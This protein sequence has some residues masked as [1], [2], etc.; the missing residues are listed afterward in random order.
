[1]SFVK[2]HA[3][4]WIQ[5]SG[6][7]RVVVVENLLI[8][9]ASQCVFLGELVP[10]IPEL[11][12]GMCVAGGFRQI[13]SAGPAD[14]VFGS[15]IGDLDQGAGLE[16]AP[17]VKHPAEYLARMVPAGVKEH[18]SIVAGLNICASCVDA[19][20]Y[21][22]DIPAFVLTVLDFPIDQLLD[23]YDVRPCVIDP[24]TLTV[25]D[26]VLFKAIEKRHEQA[27]G[28]VHYGP[29]IG[30]GKGYSPAFMQAFDSFER[31][32][33]EIVH[34]GKHCTGRPMVIDVARSNAFGDISGQRGP[35]NYPTNS[36]A[37]LLAMMNL[38][39]E[40]GLSHYANDDFLAVALHG[41]G[42]ACGANHTDNAR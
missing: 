15:P 19:G 36:A 21:F 35:N 23:S 32:P 33:G 13:L 10:D 30:I 3:L 17:L 5:V 29:L 40:Q 6:F 20:S 41:A 2:D 12:E 38:C 25:L 9:R 27:V 14:E 22:L 1:M 26:A 39:A 34:N 37:G 28:F 11:E 42:L 8:N 7:G 4:G 18:D 16:L 24:N 31:Q